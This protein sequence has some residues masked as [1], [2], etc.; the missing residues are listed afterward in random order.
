M[1]EVRNIKLDL[2]MGN[3]N[4]IVDLFNKIT[5]GIRIITC[6]VYHKDGLEFIY[7]VEN[8]QKETEWIFYQDVKNEEFWCNNGRYWSLFESNFDLEYEEIQSITKFLVEEALKRELS[9]PFFA[10][11]SFCFSV[12]EALKR[13]VSTPSGEYLL[14]INR[15][16][17]ALERE[18]GT[19][20][21]SEF[22]P[23]DVVEEA[24]EREVGTSHNSGYHVTW[25]V[26]EA[27]ERELGTPYSCVDDF[28]NEVEEAL[29]R[30][31]N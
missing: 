13:E 12:E 9:T 6:D 18:V 25:K 10:K 2:L 21:T 19:P 30:E 23:F 3:Q 4:P 29:K 5:D 31:V 7:F 26:E 24:L 28:S 1:K 22:N 14:G 17:E 20:S 27:L 8:S 16:E 11:R 15:V